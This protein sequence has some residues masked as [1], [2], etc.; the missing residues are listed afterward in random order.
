[1][2]SHVDFLYLRVARKMMEALFFY[3]QAKGLH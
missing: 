3:N 1:M 2:T